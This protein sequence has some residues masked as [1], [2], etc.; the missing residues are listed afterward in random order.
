MNI[1]LI[2][3]RGSGKTTVGRILA[4][5]LGREFVEMDELITRKAGLT[6]TEMVEKYGWEKFRELEEEVTEEIAKMDNIIN[7]SGGG[8]V[9]REKNI[10][11]L[12][13]KG[14]LVWLQASLDTLVRRIGK[15]TDRPPLTKGRTLREDMEITFK[16]RERL[17]QQAADLSID[18]ENKTPE[19]V[20]EDIINLLKIQV[21]PV[22]DPDTRIYC[23]IGDPVAHS[24]SPLIHNAGYKALG[25]NYA[26]F[27]FRVSDI[28]RAIEGI[29][30]LGIRGASVTIP[31]KTKAIKYMD[32][33]DPMAQK[34]G[35][36]NTIVNDGGILTGYNSDGEGAI[37]ALEEVTTLKDKK[38]VLI[39]AGGAA[40]AITW[41]LKAKGA[42]LVILNRTGAKAKKLAEKVNAEGYGSLKKLP[43]I[44]S[45]DI[46]INATSV[47]MWPEVNQS[48]IPKD[49]LHNKL[50]VF[51]IVYNPKETRLI[52][53]ARDRGCAVVYGYKMLLH[54]AAEQFK[55]FTGLKAPLKAMESALIQ[56]LEGGRDAA[57]FD[58]R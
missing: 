39:G 40:L 53:E 25:I 55:L 57:H 3:L 50:T 46:L 51:D 28:K 27:S 36:V 13:E 16:E 6:I 15:D 34:T 4:R 33:I 56:A 58:R 7:A 18:T 35:A 22:I 5:K 47:G 10:I 9:T 21:I 11:R 2:G 41:G 54:Q 8:V 14:V 32:K 1:V 12:K 37:K 42:R 44:A 24:L 23:L 43:E 48:I 38:V 20:A 29:R 31:H 19:Q 52:A 45:A 26:Y 30:E 17:Y 49:L